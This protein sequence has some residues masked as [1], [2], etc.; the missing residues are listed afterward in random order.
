MQYVV[1][2]LVIAVFA[3]FIGVANFLLKDSR[4]SEHA[5]KLKAQQYQRELETCRKENH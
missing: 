3:L 4:K 1:A 5:A 2:V